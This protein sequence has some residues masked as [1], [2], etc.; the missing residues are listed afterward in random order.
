VRWRRL[1]AIL[2]DALELPREQQQAFMAS[3][4]GDTQEL[5]ELQALQAAGQA[6]DTLLDG[7]PSAAMV[8]AVEARLSAS[9]LGREVGGYRLVELIA[10]GGM[11]QVYRAERLGE[12]AGGPQVAIKLM[13]DGLVD[14]SL[15]QRF[16]AER[17]TLAKLDHPHLARLL[18]GGIADGIPYFVM[19]LVLGEPIDAY[20]KRHG[21]PLARRIGLLRTLCRVVHYAHGQG[22]VH[23]D[24][25]PANVLVTTEGVVKLV[26]FGIAKNLGDTA[27][28][29][30]ATAMR[31]MTLACA[32]PEQVRG[33]P[34][35]PASDVYSLGVLL[36][37]LTTWRSPYRV[38]AASDDLD[39]R[40]AICEATPAPPSRLLRGAARRE[41]GGDLD[42]VVMKALRKEPGRRYAS[43]HDLSEDLRRHL[44]G[45]PVH[46]RW[47]WAYRAGRYA[48][49]RR[50][51]VSAAAAACVVAVAGMAAAWHARSQ[52]SAQAL[53][54]RQQLAVMQEAVSAALESQ[55][56]LA[57]PPG[58]A[59]VEGPTVQAYLDRLARLAGQGLKDAGSQAGLGLADLR[60]AQMQGGPAG[61]HLGDDAGAAQSYAAAVAAFDRAAQAGPSAGELRAVR[62]GRAQAWGGWARLLAA[63]GRAHEAR[64]LAGQALAE[65]RELGR[66][67]GGGWDERRLMAA[68]HLDLAQA[69]GADGPV[70]EMAAALES[71]L[72]L[73]EAMHKE[74]PADPAVVELLAAA[75]VGLGRYLLRADVEEPRSAARAASELTQGVALLA[76]LSSGHPQTLRWGL[77]LGLAQSQLGEALLL[78]GQQGQAIA[79]SRQ[80][81]DSIRSLRRAAPGLPPVQQRFAAVSQSLGK[82]LL[83]TGAAKDL[84]AAVEA[85]SEAA[86]AFEA[87]EKS[88][89]GDRVAQLQHAQAR[90]DLGQALLA[91]APAS[92]GAGG[93]AIPADW[94]SA[95]GHFRRSLEGMAPFEGRW[96][97]DHLVPDA[98]RVIEMQQVLLTCPKA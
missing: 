85:A 41:V 84:D 60:V 13:R 26:D 47:G 61:I 63:Q 46:A 70:P 93:H 78:D 21:L 53:L 80:A 69:L 18:G 32:S 68:A 51:L 4:A 25:K 7:G 16:M 34:I 92:A 39:V 3:Q 90:Y 91:R 42:A 86:E 72:A 9:W 23:R 50:V 40:K 89:P 87:L 55:G 83:V 6:G 28:T 79:N 65:A 29:G 37:H 64:T 2:G 48:R 81:R 57:P 94:L 74:N 8:E 58:T 27:Q 67:G 95:C 88:R 15:E 31:V 14:A 75:H 73:L 71:A 36:Y 59:S 77:D 43:A 38:D 97:G 66:I 22:V 35:T 82:L 17:Q 56:R 98:A 33:Q 1:K 12:G 52:A 62:G 45:L 96:S 19:E 44:E 76:D 20:C 49:R 5:R 54:A 24:L 10:R 11:G 30:T